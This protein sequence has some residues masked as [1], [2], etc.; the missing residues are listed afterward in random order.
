MT[1]RNLYFLAL[2]LG[3]AGQIWIVYSYKKLERQE[4]A[5]NTCIFNRVTGLP[6]P[7]C[8]TIHSI[9]SI[10]HGNFRQALMENPLGYLGFLIVLIIPYWILADLALGRESFYRF[11]LLTDRLLKIPWVLI[12]FLSLIFLLWMVKLVFFLH[13][14]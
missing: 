10:I 11:F 2:F 7:S 1:R 5:F 3:L 14:F 12:S 4:E 6:C 13:W 9:V 8:G